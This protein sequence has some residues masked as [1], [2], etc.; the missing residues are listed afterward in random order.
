MIVRIWVKPSVAISRTIPSLRNMICIDETI[1]LKRR[2]PM[3]EVVHTSRIKIVRENGPTRRAMIEG[4]DSPVYYGVH[5]GIKRFYKI[6]PEKEHAATLDHIV[7]A[8]AA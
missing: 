3:G 5:G 1:N 6:E 8:T 2:M 4:F 7:A